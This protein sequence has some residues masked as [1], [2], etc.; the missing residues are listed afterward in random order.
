MDENQSSLQ[1]QVTK[2]EQCLYKSTMNRVAG[3]FE[4]ERERERDREER[5]KRERREG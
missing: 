1:S 2:K 4:R 5:E 3:I